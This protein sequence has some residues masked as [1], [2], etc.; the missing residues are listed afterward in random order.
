LNQKV[1][2]ISVRDYSKISPQFW[3]SSQGR[4]IRKLG[5]EAQHI[6]LYLM[7]CPHSTMI[8]IYYLPLTFIVHE[9]GIP[10]EGALKAI[11]NLNDIGFCHYDFE[12]EYVWVVDMAYE[13]VGGQLKENDN[14]V[15]GI[16]DDYRSLPNLSFLSEFF[17]RYKT[18]FHLEAVR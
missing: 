4:E 12:M 2:S 8:G 6:A 15:K 7:T 17:E 1:W 18:L 11:Q 5:L 9:T 13:Q 16:N 3:I 14:R 10:F